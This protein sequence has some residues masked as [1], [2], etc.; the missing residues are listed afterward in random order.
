MRQDATRQEEPVQ[1]EYCPK[2]FVSVLRVGVCMNET[3]GVGAV[4][5]YV[6]GFVGRWESTSGSVCMVIIRD[7]WKGVTRI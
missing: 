4:I 1:R 5:L 6:G 7:E 2:I 3:S